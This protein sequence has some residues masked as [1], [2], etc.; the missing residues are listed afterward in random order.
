MRVVCLTYLST[1]LHTCL[2]AYLPTCLPAYLPTTHLEPK[3]A[4]SGKGMNDDDFVAMRWNIYT[5]DVGSYICSVYHIYVYMIDDV[6]IY[7][8]IPFCDILILLPTYYCT[9]SDI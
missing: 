4:P 5:H 8:C 7:T 6:L 9:Y 2:P 1:C 3:E